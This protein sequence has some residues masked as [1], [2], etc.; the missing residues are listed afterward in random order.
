M[1]GEFS[2]FEVL[3]NQCEEENQEE[4]RLHFKGVQKELEVAL[5]DFQSEVDHPITQI[6]VNNGLIYLPVFD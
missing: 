5:E 1:I 6:K 2:I 3:E 4:I